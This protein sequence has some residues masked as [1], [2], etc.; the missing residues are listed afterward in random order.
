MRLS[1]P[2]LLSL[3][4]ASAACT[5]GPTS[6]W[7]HRNSD[8]GND[9]K[10]PTT[11]TS[12]GKDTTKPPSISTGG[13]TPPGTMPVQMV[14]HGSGPASFDAGTSTKA[15]ADDTSSSG[16]P[17]TPATGSAG[18]SAD[19]GTPIGLDG[20]AGF[21]TVSSAA[22]DGGCADASCLARA[23]HPLSDSMNRAGQCLAADDVALACTGELSSVVS[24]CAMDDARALGLG[25]GVSACARSA[26]SLERASDS[27][28]DCYVSETLCAVQNCLALCL[29]GRSPEC[30]S[31]RT[32][33]C[34][35]AFQA[36]SG[37]PSPNP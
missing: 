31:C 29:A 1:F 32:D 17:S 10:A 11:P 14:P 8:D 4:C 3:L 9:D 26:A 28:I 23:Q 19:A 7:P 25:G 18:G 6:D 16:T 15:P 27:C 2:A 13:S 37:L 34:G 12:G 35:A 33:R 30:I 22:H 5:G 24:A 20:S 21:C 36:C